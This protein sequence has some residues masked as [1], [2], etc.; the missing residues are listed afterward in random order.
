[1]AADRALALSVSVASALRRH[2][3][4]FALIGASALAVHGHARATYDVDFLVATRRVFYIPWERE[5][6]G[7]AVDRR[8][9]EYDDPIGGVVRLS[10]PEQSPVD[11][12]VAKWKWEAAAI[13]RSIETSFAETSVPVPTLTDLVLLKIAA[14]GPQDLADAAELASYDPDALTRL[15]E[16][17]ETLPSAL[18]KEVADFIAKLD[19]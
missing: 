16:L 15:S 17:A 18:R 9:A 10:A 3:I 8:R 5:L 13:S 14:G 12:V 6:A 1:M 7:V 11:I 4:P 2:E 19:L